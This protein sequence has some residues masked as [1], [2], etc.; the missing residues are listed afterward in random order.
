[1]E[2]HA[3]QFW[4]EDNRGTVLRAH[5]DE[6]ILLEGRA[7]AYSCIDMSCAVHILCRKITTATCASGEGDIKL[8]SGCNPF[9]FTEVLSVCS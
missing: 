3:Q 4:K 5:M 1:M 2:G 9:L 7:G 6:S 8:F